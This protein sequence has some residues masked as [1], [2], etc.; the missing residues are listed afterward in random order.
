M[1]QSEL[2]GMIK[3][4]IK[5]EK[6]KLMTQKDWNTSMD[7]ITKHLKWMDKQIDKAIKDGDK[8]SL[9]YYTGYVD[10]FLKVMKK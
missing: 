9:D 7:K 4:I 10:K 2:K 1:K 8:K 6:E 3:E 5:E